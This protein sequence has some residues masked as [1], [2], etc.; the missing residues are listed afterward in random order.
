MLTS[1]VAVPL[2]V[3]FICGCTLQQARQGTAPDSGELEEV[4][5]GL[6]RTMQLEA[7]I[8]NSFYNSL[9]MFISPLEVT[10]NGCMRVG[11][12][13]TVTCAPT[14]EQCQYC[15][16]HGATN[17]AVLRALSCKNV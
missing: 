14:T 13:L 7:T 15:V 17:V 9:Y 1:F 11:C 2:G 5:A 8:D 4:L 10:R 3:D 16:V 12:A 6:D